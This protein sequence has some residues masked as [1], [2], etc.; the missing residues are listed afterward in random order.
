VCAAKRAGVPVF[1][2]MHPAIER[3]AVD[4]TT[5]CD[6]RAGGHGRRAWSNASQVAVRPRGVHAL[7]A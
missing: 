3:P 6:L 5:L 4:T 7:R 2:Q 1:P